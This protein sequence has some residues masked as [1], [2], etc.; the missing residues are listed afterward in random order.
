MKPALTILAC[1]ALAG[2]A[3]LSATQPKGYIEHY[4]QPDSYV[5]WKTA[6]G[7]F[8]NYR[9]RCIDGE[10]L[11]VTWELSQSPFGEVLV[12]ELRVSCD[13]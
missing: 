13:D 9:W 4:G 2:C 10:Y 12:S 7:D 6:E 8:L 5:V 1:V 11:S 3:G